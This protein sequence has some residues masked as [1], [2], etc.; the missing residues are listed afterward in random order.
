MKSL[1]LIFLTGLIL[2]TVGLGSCKKEASAP[3][4]NNQPNPPPG[5]VVLAPGV[6]KV[7][8][9]TLSQ[10][11]VSTDSVTVT[12][13][14][15]AA[16]EKLQ[17]GNILS[18]GISTVAPLGFLRKITSI[19]SSGGMIVCHTSMARLSDAVVSTAVTKTFNSDDLFR[20]LP[21]ANFPTSTANPLTKNTHF[22]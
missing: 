9:T 8:S 17:T 3:P 12:F 15:V 19:T 13:K 7:D 5:S 4:K 21:N 11:L 22:A 14:D 6:I 18:S 1:K 16:S 20:N 2:T 10:A